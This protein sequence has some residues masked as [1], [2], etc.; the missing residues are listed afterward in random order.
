MRVFRSWMCAAL[1]LVAAGLLLAPGAAA[2]SLPNQVLALYPQK[3]GQLVFVDAQALR[4]SPHYARIKSQVLPDRFRSLEQW[5]TALGMDFDREVRQLSWGFVSTGAGDAGIEFVGIAEGQFP[6]GGIEGRARG[7]KLAITK[8]GGS[9]MVSLG[10]SEQG[11]EFVFAFIDAS[12]AVFGSRGS[13]EEIVTRRAQGGQS[14]LDNP[15]LRDQ[16]TQLNG[17]RA[18]VWFALDRR[19]SGLALKQMLP[20]ASQ[21]QGF[22]AMAARVVSTTMKIDLRSG[23][24]SQAAVRCQDAG[25]C[26]LLSSAA[27]AGF[28]LQ[29]LRLKDSSPELARA[30]G[31]ARITRSDTRVD[32]EFQ[33]AES[34]FAA[35]LARNGLTLKF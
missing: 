3:T 21:V 15:A 24:A 35:L 8:P 17:S 7:L 16:I 30:L 20:E 10:K 1:A 23:L 25:D 33:L 6:L 27:Q 4:R 34:Q 18:P 5:T 29:A 32:V 13:V 14:L 26:V 2:Q 9:T 22:D 12:T 28:A 31:D 19:F 11:S